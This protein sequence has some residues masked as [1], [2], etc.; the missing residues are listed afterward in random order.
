MTGGN[1]S[2]SYF[3]AATPSIAYNADAAALQTALQSVS[4][5]GLVE[6]SLQSGAT[7]V[8]ATAPGV[9]TLITFTS[10]LGSQ[11]LLLAT[12]QPT[13]AGQGVAVGRV[14]AGT[15]VT[16]GTDAS[17]TA[18]WDADSLYGCHCDGY[19]DFNKTSLANGDTGLF[20]GADCS[21]RT[22]PWGTDPEAANCGVTLAPENQTITCVAASTASGSFTLSFR[23]AV[24]APIYASDTAATLATKL[25]DVVSV[26]VVSVT[27][28]GTGTGGPI[29]TAGGSG[30]VS[31]VTFLTELGDLPPM[32][33]ASNT[34]SGGGSVTVATLA[35]GTG[36]PEECAGR[37]IC[38][39][40]TAL[41]NCF[42]NYGSSNGF[43]SRG[44]RGDCGAVQLSYLIDP[45]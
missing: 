34:L 11:P 29:C 9:T 7:A 19:P 44:R 30:A 10:N 17:S 22:C 38:D 25:G 21:L 4:T 6:V 43:G 28:T 18:T 16:Y 32:T 2:L 24:T 12:A 5:V 15:R 3:Y 40:S 42:T 8:C 45:R 20:A 41:C 13:T 14:T 39:T 37:G 36:T 23:G 31:T 33:V 1:F 35:D 26:G 27:T